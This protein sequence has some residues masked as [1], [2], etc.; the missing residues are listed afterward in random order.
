MRNL[1]LA[2]VSVLTGLL[3][4]Y[5][6]LFN[7]SL[8]D[9]VMP[10]LFGLE[11]RG[12][13]E[14]LLTAMAFAL[15]APSIFAANVAIRRLADFFNP[16]SKRGKERMKLADH[17]VDQ[18]YRSIGFF[19]AARGY[20]QWEQIFSDIAGILLALVLTWVALSPVVGRAAA[21]KHVTEH[22]HSLKKNRRR[23]VSI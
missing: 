4:V 23:Q 3:A 20:I 12:A 7:H 17:Q 18:A 16:A 10:Q 21:V 8:F 2:T 6:R 5:S 19:N 14:H 15:A 11:G 22:L 13:I 9:G 1:L